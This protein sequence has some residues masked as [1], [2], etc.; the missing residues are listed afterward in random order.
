M[1]ASTENTKKAQAEHRIGMYGKK[2]SEDT[3]AKMKNNNSMKNLIHIQEVTES[4]KGI[5]WLTNGVDKKMAVPETEKF[6]ILIS[7]WYEVVI[8]KSRKL[9]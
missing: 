4:K 2:Q 6:S 1:R 5:K 3:I 7:K 8:R 9:I